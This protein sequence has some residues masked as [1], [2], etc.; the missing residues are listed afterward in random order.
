MSS[1]KQKLN[2]S[3]AKS[4]QHDPFAALRFRDYRLFTIGRTKQELVTSF[5]QGCLIP[6]KALNFVELSSLKKDFLKKVFTLIVM[7]NLMK[8]YE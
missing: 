5:W 1:S 4:A 6:T 8:Y 7:G 2:G 3:N